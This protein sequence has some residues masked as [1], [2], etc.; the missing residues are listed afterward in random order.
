MPPEPDLTDSMFNRRNT[1]RAIWV[2]IEGE[3]KPL[4]EWCKRYKM[5][6]RTVYR[7]VK[8][9]GWCIERALTEPITFSRRNRLAKDA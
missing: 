7:R 3:R 4:A 8:E 5:P 6:Y 9:R 1:K 2:T